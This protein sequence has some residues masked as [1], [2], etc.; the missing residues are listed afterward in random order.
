MINT[1]SAPR[2]LVTYCSSAIFI[3]GLLALIIPS[4]YSVGAVLL[5]LGGL[6]AYTQ[7]K[8]NPLETRDF[9]LLL[10]LVAF[11]LEGIGNNLWHD[12]G[13]SHYD[14]I[15]R[16]T[17]AIPTFYLLRWTKP[18]L[19]WAWAGLVAGSV[20][21]GLLAIYEKLFLALERSGGFHHSIQFGNLS[22][23][24]GLFCLAGLGW[25][26]SLTEIKHRRIYFTLLILGALSGILGSILSGSRGG[27]IGLPFVFLVLFKAYHNYFTLRTKIFAFVFA[28][29]IGL[30]VFN[31]PQLPI[32]DRIHAAIHDVQQYQAGYKATSVGSRFEMWRGATELIKEKPLL[33]WGQ[34]EYVTAIQELVT[35]GKIDPATTLFTHSHNEILNTTAK[36]GLVGLLALIAL[37][38][39]PIWYFHPYLKHS[40]LSLRALAVAGTI[41]P[42]AYIDFG[43]TQ[44]F[45]SH[46]SG[47]MMYA[48]WLMIWAGY[49]RNAITAYQS[50]NTAP[51]ATVP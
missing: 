40:N 20:G 26:Y 27:W 15:L 21:A 31:L 7:D 11:T 34:T 41:L 33:G 29:L 3:F 46:N 23:L 37:Y 4:G 32:K 2:W 30:T 1:T 28:V 42:V 13:S 8:Q 44:S 18:K 9:Y 39:A 14:K 16:F 47:V 43:F 36:N 24:M 19:H 45:L 10:V 22:M 17:L 5:L 51:A 50:P 25:A 6:Y 12:L 38:L 35:Q 49:L 48:F